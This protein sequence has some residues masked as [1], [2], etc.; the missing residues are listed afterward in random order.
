M[1]LLKGEAVNA[2]AHGYP[3]PSLR[4]Q[5]GL[6]TIPSGSRAAIGTQSEA[7]RLTKIQIC[8]IILSYQIYEGDYSDVG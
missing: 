1:S 5:E 2:K 6:T 8:A 7:V 3:L 4:K